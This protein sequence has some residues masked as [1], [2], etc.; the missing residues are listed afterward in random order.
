M[1]D[2]AMSYGGLFFLWYVMVGAVYARICRAPGALLDRATG[3]PRP[4]SRELLL[5]LFMLWPVFYVRLTYNT[6]K[7]RWR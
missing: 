2:A 1:M 7:D 5:G 3:R 4:A 6:L